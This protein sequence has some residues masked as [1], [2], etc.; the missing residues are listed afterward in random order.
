MT[1]IGDPGSLSLWGHDPE[2]HRLFADHA[3]A[4]VP[5]RAY[6]QG[7][8]VDEWR[9]LPN[10]DQHYPDC[11][12]ASAAAASYLGVTLPG[13]QPAAV[14]KKAREKGRSLRITLR[15]GCFG[16]SPNGHNRKGLDKRV[17]RRRKL[18]RSCVWTSIYVYPSRS[19]TSTLSGRVEILTVA[20]PTI[21][22]R[23]A[24]PSRLRS[25]R[26]AEAGAGLILKGVEVEGIDG[27]RGRSEIVLNMSPDEA[28]E[29]ARLILANGIASP[30][31]N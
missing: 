20:L 26:T 15:G 22:T 11:I 21:G 28:R 27:D 6:G 3:C 29:L 25:V 18:R 7:R 13:V 17:V 9:Q 12:V 10:Q 19:L 16:M 31:R 23:V 8:C 5:V 30:E 2:M 24:R 14:P 1:A 4:E